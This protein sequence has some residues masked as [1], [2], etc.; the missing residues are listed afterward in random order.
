MLGSWDLDAGVLEILIVLVLTG[1]F[2]SVLGVR[3]NLQEPIIALVL[4][5]D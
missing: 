4:N 5:N 1:F 2:H 3:R